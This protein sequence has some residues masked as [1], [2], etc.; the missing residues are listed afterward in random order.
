MHKSAFEADLSLVKSR[1]PGGTLVMW[2][3]SVNPNIANL[4]SQSPIFQSALLKIPGTLSSIHTALYLPTSGKE[5]QFASCLADLSAHISDV[6]SNYPDSPHFLRGDANVNSNNKT[7]AGLFNYF[8]STYNFKCIP[9]PV[10][11]RLYISL[12]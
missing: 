3:N 10:R 11:D 9:L 8:C 1:A 5:E 4:P 12:P 6:R 7:R 2:H